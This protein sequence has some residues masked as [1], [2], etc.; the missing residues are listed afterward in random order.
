[1]AP[2][3][4]PALA[5]PAAGGLW[6]RTGLTPMPNRIVRDVILTSE[7]VA[8]LAW[9]EEVFYRRLMSIV[10]DFGRYEAGEQLLRSRCYP[11][12]TDN[13]R[14]ADISRWMAACQKAGLILGYEVAGKRYL[15]VLNFGQQQRTA[16]KFPSPPSGASKCDQLQADECLGVFG[17]GDDKS[18]PPTEAPA[19]PVDDRPPLSLVGSHPEKPKDPPDC[20]HLEVLALWAEVLPALPQ[21]LPSQWRGARADHLRTR[22]RETACEKG[23]ADQAQGLAYMRKLFGYVGRSRFL[24]GR[25]PQRDPA[26]RP[27]VIELE[28]LVLPSNWAKVVEGKFHEEAG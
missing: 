28:W 4:T 24:T 20:P 19:R 25:A 16:S 23:W 10:D 2:Y 12:Q 17:V 26:K 27:F 18:K 7:R 22:W 9:P 14:T 1:M 6:G 3:P 5:Q 11:L 8:A 15:E 13:V 21:H